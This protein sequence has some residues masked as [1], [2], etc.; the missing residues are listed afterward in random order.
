MID[1]VSLPVEDL[2]SAA[3]FYD[4]V[5]GTLG[6]SR[7]K[8]FS[9]SVGYGSAARP[10]PIFWILGPSSDQS[11]QPGVGLHVSF[12]APDCASVDSFFDTAIKHGGRGAG[13]PGPRPEYTQPF[14]GAFVLDPNGFKIEAVCRR[15]P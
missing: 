7:Q 15:E 11:A 13:A 2:V 4:A 3:S 10:A 9:G 1:H 6:L 14:Y 12:E 8:E 5:L